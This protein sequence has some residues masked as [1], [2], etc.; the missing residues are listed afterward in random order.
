MEEL[1]LLEKLERVKAP[2]DFEQKVLNLLSERK[3]KRRL[4]VR[5]LRLSFAGAFVALL[6]CFIVLN[7][8][9][10]QRKG[11]TDISGLGRGVPAGAK[12]G[13]ILRARDY[14]PIIEAVDYSGEIQR[15][16]YESQTI[17]IL[18]RVS[19]ERLEQVKY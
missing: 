3:E 14:L 9:V 6:V 16:S 7:V 13:E 19:E 4:G 5:N 17:Y 12:R 8:F 2:S 15:P 10:L 11:P 18:E 1:N